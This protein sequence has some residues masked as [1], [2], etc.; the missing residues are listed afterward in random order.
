M[1][2]QALSVLL[3]IIIISPSA[4]PVS[5]LPVDI[6]LDVSAAAGSLYGLK[7]IRARID[8][9]QKEQAAYGGQDVR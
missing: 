1:Q 3:F 2:L 9:L 4:P 8:H 6:V 7:R 5:S